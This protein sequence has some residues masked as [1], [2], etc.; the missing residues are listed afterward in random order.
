MESLASKPL[1]II[2][3]TELVLARDARVRYTDPE[4]PL[5]DVI[6]VLKVRFASGWILS[7]LLLSVSPIGGLF[8]YRDCSE[9]FVMLKCTGVDLVA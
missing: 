3:M 9:I 7:G 2:C 8:D 1:L 6:A 5:G 4:R